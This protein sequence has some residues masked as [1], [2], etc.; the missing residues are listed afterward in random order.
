MAY[1]IEFVLEFLRSTLLS[2]LRQIIIIIYIQPSV[3]KL[4]QEQWLLLYAIALANVLLLL[5]E[6][7]HFT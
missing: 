1:R 4:E 3:D 2:K 6:F 5:L 7:I